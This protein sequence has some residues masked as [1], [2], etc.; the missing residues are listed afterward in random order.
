[1][2]PPHHLCFRHISS[3]LDVG[4]MALLPPDVLVIHLYPGKTT[5]LS[6]PSSMVTFEAFFHLIVLMFSFTVTMN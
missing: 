5:Y 2:P 4:A 3:G 1:M 6:Q